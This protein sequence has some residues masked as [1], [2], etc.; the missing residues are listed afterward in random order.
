VSVVEAY[1]QKNQKDKDKV[2]AY[3]DEI[4]RMGAAMDE[5]TIAQLE[6]ELSAVEGE[7]ETKSSSFKMLK[8]EY[9]ELLGANQAFKATI[10]DVETKTRRLKARMSIKSLVNRGDRRSPS[11]GGANGKRDSPAT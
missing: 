10:D 1:V 7:L 9:D 6:E 4:R 11:R 8:S 5:E 2:S 3:E